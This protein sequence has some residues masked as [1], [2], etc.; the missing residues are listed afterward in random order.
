MIV[1]QLSIQLSFFDEHK[2]HFA[3]KSLLIGWLVHVCSVKCIPQFVSVLE[4]G[5]YNQ[6]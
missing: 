6:A 4:V 1:I 3:R 5:V 2:K